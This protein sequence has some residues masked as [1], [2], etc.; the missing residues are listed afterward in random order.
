MYVRRYFFMR[1]QILYY[2]L[3]YGGEYRKIKRAIEKNEEWEE[4]EYDENYITILDEEYPKEFYELDEP[5]YL[6]FYKGNLELLTKEKVSVIG[7]R[8][9]SE[10]AKQSCYD[11]MDRLK[12]DTVIV[13]GLAKGVDALAHIEA[14][15]LGHPCIGV[16]GCG[17]DIIYPMENKNLYEEI[18]NNHLLISEYPNHVAP[19][20][21]HFPARNRLIA[22]LGEV[23]YV[24]EAKSKSGTMITANYALSL[25]REIIA[26]P[27]RYNEAFGK[28]CNDLIEQGASIFNP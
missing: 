1:K 9:C 10:Y 5:P 6:F 15:K 14:M 26:F 18:M 2:G 21:H 4:T 16:I 17:L 12:N 3:K 27:Y 11:L 20:A 19:S 25:D 28:G 23:C 13:S 8:E 24:V 22:A 7:S